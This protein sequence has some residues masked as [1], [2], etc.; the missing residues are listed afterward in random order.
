[1]KAVNGNIYAV[2]AGDYMGE[3]F[4]LVEQTDQYVFLSLPDFNIRE[5]SQEQYK[6]GI[7][8]SVLDFQEKLPKDVFNECIKKYNELK[9]CSI[10]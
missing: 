4:V 6:I 7:E 5:V 10:N 8:S 2:T 3:F 9:S 1:M